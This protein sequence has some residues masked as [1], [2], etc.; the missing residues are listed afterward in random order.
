M[1]T[2]FRSGHYFYYHNRHKHKF[3]NKSYKGCKKTN[4]TSQFIAYYKIILRLCAKTHYRGY[5]G[6]LKHFDLLHLIWEITGLGSFLRSCL[7][8]S[9]FQNYYNVNF[10]RNNNK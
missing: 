5:R 10:I 7:L 2:L 4:K 3:I 8:Q 9:C 1:I 6:E